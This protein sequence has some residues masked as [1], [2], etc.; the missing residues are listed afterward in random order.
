MKTGE[1]GGVIEACVE[2]Q[3][4]GFF[5]GVGRAWLLLCLYFF[6]SLGFY[7]VMGLLKP[8][9]YKLLV[10]FMSQL[11]LIGLAIH[12]IKSKLSQS[13][14]KFEL[15]I[16]SWRMAFWIATGAFVMILFKA[17]SAMLMV[18]VSGQ[19]GGG[20]FSESSLLVLLIMTIGA[21]VSEELLFRGF[22]LPWL[23]EV[24][25][26]A[27]AIVLTSLVFAIVHFTPIQILL[28][29]ISGVF[30]GWLMLRTRS[31]LPSILYHVFN[32]GLGFLMLAF[33]NPNT[34]LDPWYIHGPWPAL[35]LIGS[36]LLAFGVYTLI[37]KRVEIDFP[38][39]KP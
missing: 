7:L 16:P 4:A 17:S 39:C 2:T 14:N 25:S 37:R 24:T 6:A 15:K 5:A 32:N 10:H 11:F 18:Q 1:N 8:D 12:L 33:R 23:L 26:P 34:S 9:K 27:R 31:L 20:L 13:R 3:S 36:A 28:T 22:G 35:F 30:S 38:E 19:L 21:P 29:F